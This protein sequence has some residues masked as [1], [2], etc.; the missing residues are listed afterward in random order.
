MT[1]IFK[2]V[3]SL[4]YNKYGPQGWWPVLSL[5]G[6]QGFDKQGYHKN[7]F[8]QPQSEQHQFEVM[9]G[10]ILTQNTSWKH[11]EKAMQNL[12]QE[13]LLN[14]KA[15]EEAD[16]QKL[17]KLIK[18][19]GYFNQKAKKIKAFLQW[20]GPVTRESL[21]SVWGVG[22]ET[23]DSIL[24]YAFHHP[25]FVIDAY[26][27][28]IFSRL[29]VCKKDVSYEK[30][31]STFMKYLVKDAQLFNEYHALLVEHAKQY[32]TSTP[33]CKTC[34]LRMICKKNI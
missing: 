12:Q 8:S 9:L 17:A 28:R 24:L 11:V 7:N 20:K 2:H 30:L 3:H 34:P 22:P 16:E 5:A 18:P 23:A 4:L 27:K 6:K 29:G 25:V 15:L 1:N 26:T 14:K 33:Q 13:G 31:Q 10:A 21:L 19:A 32:C